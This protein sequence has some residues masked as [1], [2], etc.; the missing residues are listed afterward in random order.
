MNIELISDITDQILNGLQ[1]IHSVNRK[2]LDYRNGDTFLIAKEGAEVLG[3]AHSRFSC[4]TLIALYVV[5][6]HRK[7]TKKIG[8]SLLLR[9]VEELKNNGGNRLQAGI[10]PNNKKVISFYEKY[11]FSKPSVGKTGFTTIT[12]DVRCQYT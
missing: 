5:K 2:E 12:Y 9:T 4:S 3:Y 8:S 11:G 6:E 10:E 7:S 1:K